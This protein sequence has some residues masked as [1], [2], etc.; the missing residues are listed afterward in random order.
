MK[1]TNDYN[2]RSTYLHHITYSQLP[3]VS[4]GHWY[5]SGSI[6]RWDQRPVVWALLRSY[7]LCAS[8]PIP[9]YV[10][11]VNNTYLR[12]QVDAYSTIT[13]SLPIGS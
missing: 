8:A 12:I 4:P 5:A 7:V 11:Y 3:I 6:K 10:A 2:N 9:T 13:E 1:N